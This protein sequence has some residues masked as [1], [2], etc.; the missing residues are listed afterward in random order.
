[1]HIEILTKEQTSLLP[2]I[3]K[4]SKNFYLV[5]GTAMALHLGHRRSIDFDL[6][7]DTEFDNFA[8]RRKIAKLHKIERVVTDE[9]GQYTVILRGVRL[10]F[11]H[12]PFKIHSSKRLDDIIAL[13]NL[14]TLAAM[15]AFALGRRTKWKDYVDLCFVMKQGHDIN[16]IVKKA[17]QIFSQEFNEKIFRVQL[18]YFKDINYTEQVI[19][20]KGFKI[21]DNVIKKELANFAVES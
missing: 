7:T 17:K 6:F 9:K 10:T 3:K 19:Y 13:P 21:A 12:Y 5:G 8:I 20:L 2:L 15:K 4:F 16:K 14:I 11:F 1:M 18:A